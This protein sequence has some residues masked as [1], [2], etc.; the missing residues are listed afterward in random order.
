[1]SASSFSLVGLGPILNRW[2]YLVA[3]VVVAAAVLSAAVAWRLPNQYRST[4]VFFPTNLQN[5]DPDRIVE[6]TKLE[7]TG[8]SEDLDRAITIGQSQPVAALLIKRFN[9][10]QHY[11]AGEPG[12]DKAD[13]QVLNEFGSNLDIVR[14]ERD[15]IELTFMDRDKHLAANVANVLV[16]V[17]DSVN[18][19]LTLTN[20]RRVLVLYGRR[21]DYLRTGYEQGRRQLV[22]LRARYGIF[23]FDQQ[24]RYLAKQLVQTEAALR[25]AEGGG[26]GNAAGLRRALRGLTRA[27]G[28]NAMN[29]ESFV[30]GADSLA[31]LTARVTDLQTRLTAAQGAY[32]TAEL[33]IKGQ[34]SSVYLVQP[35][36]PAT[37]KAKPVRWLIV[38]GS[39]LLTFALA[40]VIIA[41]LE[42]YRYN[43]RRLN[44]QLAVSS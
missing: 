43:Q 41:L 30:R 29:A 1:M 36:Y 19:Q 37:N 32:E 16:Q 25:Q 40:V 23:N 42:L 34:V 18:Q 7:L 5:A 2:K 12:D 33:T 28:G 21:Y 13:T 20:R 3:A 6:G 22:A 10:Y 39:V 14:N 4:A 27:D 11:K 9:L 44:E 24:S 35:A 31:L 17:I 38:V 26:G 8:R 15:A